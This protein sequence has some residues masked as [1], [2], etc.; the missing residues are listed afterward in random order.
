MG[1]D[2]G[3][4]TGHGGCRAAWKGECGSGKGHRFAGQQG[5]LAGWTRTEVVAR[6]RDEV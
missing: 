1:G 2:A 6:D 3:E 5:L 4:R